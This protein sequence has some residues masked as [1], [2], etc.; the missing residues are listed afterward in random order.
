MFAL[1]REPVP[2]PPPKK[3]RPMLFSRWGAFVYRFRRP[4]AIVTIVLAVLASTLASKATGALSS[5]GWT[6]PRS[7]STAVATRLAA[8]FGT[9]RGSIIALFEGDAS[10]D[11]RSV[12]F[13]STIATSLRR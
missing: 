13:Q 2:A 9:G 8:E 11:A 12:A 4:I 10:V 7:E 5:G 1:L 6:D 3:D